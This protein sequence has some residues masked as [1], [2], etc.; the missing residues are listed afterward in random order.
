M[1]IEIFTLLK[2]Q[3]INVFGLLLVMREFA[4]EKGLQNDVDR[5]DNYIEENRH[6]I[7]LAND[8]LLELE[9]T[10]TIYRIGFFETIK[11]L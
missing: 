4:D 6:I 3:A 7:T 9:Q 2:S 8:Q 10:N 5:L 1:D 11:S